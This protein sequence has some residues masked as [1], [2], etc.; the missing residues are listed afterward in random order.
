MIRKQQNASVVEGSNPSLPRM[1]KKKDLE[2]LVD[3]E[4][5]VDEK[6]ERKVKTNYK[7]IGYVIP[8]LTPK[9]A[10]EEHH[11]MPSPVFES[12]KGLYKKSL[13]FDTMDK[14]K[15]KIKERY[16]RDQ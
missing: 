2:D 10:A 11:I 16:G 1:A 15:A 6:K 9:Q 8:D 14:A 12:E 4:Q 3:E 7:I 5:A 13:I